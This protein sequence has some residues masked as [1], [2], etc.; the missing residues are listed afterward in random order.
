ML[1]VSLELINHNRILNRKINISTGNDKLVT[2]YW[3]KLM[4]SE[5]NQ[6]FFYWRGLEL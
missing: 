1:S 5:Q 6:C 4:E 2:D 3:L